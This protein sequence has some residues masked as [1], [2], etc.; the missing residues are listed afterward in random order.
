MVR[1]RLWLLWLAPVLRRLLD[2]GE[3]EGF[4]SKRYEL[5]GLDEGEGM[6]EG[7]W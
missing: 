2:V 1:V 6:A 5:R 4:P 3:S 7:L